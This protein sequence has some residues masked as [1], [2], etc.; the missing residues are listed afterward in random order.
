SCAQLPLTWGAGGLGA[1]GID[2]A[3]ARRN[4]LCRHFRREVDGD[5]DS[6]LVVIVFVPGRLVPIGV[7]PLAYCG[8]CSRELSGVKPDRDAAHHPL[9][10][11][12]VST[13]LSQSKGVTS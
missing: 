11:L 1:C 10:T 12:N 2:T 8:H 6:V 7:E 3:E 5:D 4:R 13:L 9:A